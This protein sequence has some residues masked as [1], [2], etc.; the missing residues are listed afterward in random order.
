M[1]CKLSKVLFV[2][3]LFYLGWFQ[4]VFFQINHMPLILGLS[5]IVV[6]I[7]HKM[8]TTRRIAFVIPKPVS[9]W[10]MFLF[11]ALLSGFCC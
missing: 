5:M 4:N 1:L 3:F 2:L 6:L 11:Y 8:E 9:V 7:L 10:L